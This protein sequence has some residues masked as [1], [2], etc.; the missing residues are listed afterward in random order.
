MSSTAESIRNAIL[1]KYP[2]IYLLTREE[3]R[4]LQL[5]D[6]FSE[7]LF[8]SDSTIRTWS[9]VRGFDNNK[10][11]TDTRDPLIALQSILSSQDKGFYIMKDFASFMKEPS[12]AR[13][14]R[15][16]YYT[17]QGKD[18]FVFLVSPELVIPESLK[19]E[20]LLIDMDLPDENELL[21][22][23]RKIQQ[24]YPQA[25]LSDDLMGRVTFALRGLTLNEST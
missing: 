12:V 22:H 20:I 24:A 11:T 14:L 3:T 9:C 23:A 15:D 16:A 6:A 10:Q 4:A 7:K 2:L 17:L 21:K 5:L 1:G 8:G 13:A 18:K 25:G 19:K